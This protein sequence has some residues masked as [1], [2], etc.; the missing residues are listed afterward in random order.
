MRLRYF[1]A[2]LGLLA[3]LTLAVGAHAAPSDLS[4]APVA[5]VTVHSLSA[6]PTVLAPDGS[7]S[8]LQISTKRSRHSRR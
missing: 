5:P 6:S 3:V 4:S 1:A 8:I 2:C 7:M